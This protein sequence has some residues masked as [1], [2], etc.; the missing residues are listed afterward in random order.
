MPEATHHSVRVDSPTP[1]RTGGP[2]TGD[3][4][5]RAAGWG[6]LTFAAVV[7]AQNVIRGV[8]AP[9]NDA[10]AA[11]VLSDYSGD[12]AIP[13]V[14]AATYVVSGVGLAVFL[15][16]VTRRLLTTS[17]RGWAV[18]GVVG[19]VGVMIV[20]TLVVAAEQ[21][22]TVVAHMDRPELGA[23]QAVWALHNSTFAVLDLWIAIALVGLS[24]AAIAAGL[25]PRAFTW[26]APLGAALLVVGVVGGPAIAAG[27]VRVLF[28]VAGMGFLIWL[29]FLI[30][31]GAR[32]VRPA[33]PDGPPTDAA[34]VSF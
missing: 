30:V 26:L 31:T 20:F 16:G 14:L 3:L 13:Y 11:T 12:G 27:Q 15:G 8:F 19:A 25:T 2:A 6:A 23:I 5:S 34:A 29:A 4:S 33:G 24:R 18:T 7:V 22:L 28:G 17:R 21:A 1:S 32:L 9:A 10:S